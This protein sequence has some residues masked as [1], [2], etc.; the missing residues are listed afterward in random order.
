MTQMERELSERFAL[1]LSQKDAE[2]EELRARIQVLR[3]DIISMLS[4]GDY[5]P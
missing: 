3:G 5:K 4:E 1:I 2:I